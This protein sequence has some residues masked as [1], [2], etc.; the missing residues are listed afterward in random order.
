LAERAKVGANEELR[1]GEQAEA[2]R[3]NRTR[4]N[5][6]KSEEQKEENQSN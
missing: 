3:A 2:V 4:E 1:A 6:G 5:R